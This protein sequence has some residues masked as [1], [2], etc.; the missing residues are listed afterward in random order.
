MDKLADLKG[1]AVEKAP[2][3]GSKAGE[4]VEEQ[5]SIILD[6][7]KD[8]ESGKADIKAFY[9]ELGKLGIRQ[10]DPR[11]SNMYKM[12]QKLSTTSDVSILKLDPHTFKAVLSEN[13]VFIT[14]AFQ[15]RLVIPAFETFNENITE[16]Y[17]K[18]K[19]NTAG[20]P[21]PFLKKVIDHFDDSTFG[22]SIC[23]VDGQRF[24]IGDAT[25]PFSLQS[26]CRPI[27]YGIALNELDE[28]VH[29][30]QGREP[31]G[32][33]KNEIALDHN[34]K[35][36]NP[37]ENS[38]GIMSSSLLVQNV[39]PEL[40][41][42]ARK[43]EYVMNIFESMAGGEM[44]QFNNSLLL[45][46]KSSMDRDFSLAYFMR[47]NGC[48]P[49][50]AD[51]KKI[52]EFYFQLTA[53]E[54]NCESNSVMA[55]TL[56]NGGTCPITGERILSSDAVSHVLALMGS[57]GMSIY[58]GQFAFENGLPAISS[59]SGAIMLVIP[60]VAGITIL[61]P[62]L[63]HLNNPVR[64]VD[65]C[66]EL[67]KLY[68][69]HKYDTIGGGSSVKLDPTLK[70]SYTALELGIQLLFASANGDLV[71]LRRAFM[72]DVDMDISD[73]D[74]RTPTHLAAAEGH[75]NCVKFLLETCKANPDQKDRWNQTPLSEAMRHRHY[76]VVKYIKEYLD[77]N[78]NAGN[79][80]PY[81]FETTG[82]T[83]V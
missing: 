44:V 80:R 60:D 83:A 49:P 63:D 50:G 27:T 77:N 35:P 16:I 25:K 71:Y 6:I 59:S 30:Y 4:Q 79:E 39:K 42:L 31:S 70:R 76:A 28:E 68:Q 43:Y 9:N 8:E 5:I 21:D 22:I 67:I 64:G 51:I 19:L 29:K 48:F 62:K 37:Y 81:E 69:F 78:P 54:M 46:L 73:Y 74:G 7:C 32:R 55:G 56:A 53:L 61:S 20:E 15:N 26:L 45:S 72:N 38:G 1:E 36:Y 3:E 40:D 12:L 58:S 33:M 65:F 82:V 23:T 52:L 17:H 10:T 11:L 41:D 57:C 24:S 2:S 18:L 47:E 66:H 34:R 14:K 75:L 13:I